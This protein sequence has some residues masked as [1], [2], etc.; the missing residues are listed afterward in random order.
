MSLWSHPSP[1]LTRL[2]AFR[3]H[4]NKKY[5]LA[6]ATYDQLHKWSTDDLESF[7][8]E[9]FNFC[10]LVTSHAP[11]RVA[12]GLDKMWPRPQWFPDALLNFTENILA[13][14]LAA[15]P[16]KIAVSACRE[17]GTQWRELTWR[18]LQHE[19]ARYASALRHANVE[20]G[21]RV[22]SW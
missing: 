7:Y 5:G 10:G 16:D 19:V 2:D 3:R 22:A 9:L 8:Q 11:S 1:H 13:T 21:D 15:H 14:G 17:G 6:L 20:K 18:Q 12:D 4:V